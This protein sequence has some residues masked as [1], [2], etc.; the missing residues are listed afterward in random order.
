MLM[1]ASSTTHSFVAGLCNVFVGHPIDL[2]KVRQQ[3]S[4]TR[5]LS[6][7]PMLRTILA[8]QGMTGLYAGVNAALIAVVPAFAV[9]FATFDCAKTVMLNR[10]QQ[11]Q[12]S[13]SQTASAGAFS[14]FFLAMVLGPFERIKCLMQ[15]QHYPS[16]TAC[17]RQLYATGGVRSIYKGTFVTMLRDVPG[18]AAYF[19]AYEA[20][21][22][23]LPSSPMTTLLAGGMAGVANWLVSI[24]MDV[25]KSQWQT[26]PCG[27]YSH[28]TRVVSHLYQTQ[29][30]PAF[31]RGLGPALGRA[32][33][34][35][36]ACLFGVE[37][38]R[39]VLPSA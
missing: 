12:L 10:S 11:T 29:G 14:G 37:A 25:V 39:S 22:R 13:I 28:W 15:V 16:M 34:A 32:F 9:S 20:T 18:N 31:T 5:T 35:N 17:V 19:A 2:V 21:Q 26:A 36:A 30:L 33:P 27:T 6:A 23:S 4:S 1:L 38:A 7:I 8:S 24:P 3:A